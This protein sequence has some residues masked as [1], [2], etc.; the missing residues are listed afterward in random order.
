MSVKRGLPDEASTNG[1][2]TPLKRDYH[3]LDTNK[4]DMEACAQELD[5]ED[6]TEFFE[7]L[8]ETSWHLLD[9]SEDATA[10]VPTLSQPEC[11]TGF[12][13]A[14]GKQLARPSDAAMQ[15][16][17]KRLKLDDTDDGALLVHTPE[18]ASILAQA[19][20]ATTPQRGVFQ[21]P[22]EHSKPSISSTPFTRMRPASVLGTSRSR[23]LS[24]ISPNT[25]EHFQKPIYLGITP[26]SYR[27]GLAAGASSRTKFTPPFKK[28]AKLE[29][30]APAPRVPLFNL[31]PCMLRHSYQQLGLVPKRTAWR[32]AVSQ[33]VPLEA[34]MI[35]Q[36]PQQAAHYLF[37]TAGATHGPTELLKTLHRLGAHRATE[38]WV[39]NHYAV[40]LW[41]LAG[42][43][44]VCPVQ[45]HMYWSY[46]AVLRQMRYRYER[47]VHCGQSSVVKQIQEQRC[48]PGKPMVL[49]VYHIHP[50]A[51]SEEPATTILQLTDGWYRIRAALDA[52]LT[53]A[54]ERG[55]IR[56]GQKLG[57]TAAKLEAFGEGTPVLDAFHTSD[58]SISANSCQHMRWDTRLGAHPRSF[59]STL[60]RLIADGGIVGLMDICLDRVY[61]TG[62]IQGELDARGQTVFTGS[63][64]GT[65]EEQER[66]RAWA[67]QRQEAQGT[68]ALM[69][70]RVQASL[71][72][73]EPR[74]RPCE[75]LDAVSI[76]DV[77]SLLADVE[78]TANPCARLE[79]VQRE[80][81]G[82]AR[83]AALLWSARARASALD[84][85]HTD[86]HTSILD[87]LC[88]P[89]RVKAFCI[90][91][92]HD[93]QRT[94]RTT[95]RSV[96]LTVWDPPPFLKEGARLQVSHLIPTQRDAWRARDAAA[97]VFLATTR[98]TTWHHI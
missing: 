49:C 96:Q 37:R 82:Q 44:A 21:S 68:L 27:A 19:Q 14:S 91:R 76:Q 23:P 24:P 25:V 65:D 4:A 35:L 72:W 89:R 95:R 73:L 2:D 61:P 56:V 93:A 74:V 22:C 55:K 63:Q 13:N 75:P 66:Q 38:K 32:E 52:P 90:V 10:A 58:L 94:K 50:I 7:S 54:V 92:F 88:A 3:I 36:D 1:A 30:D 85:P 62:Y 70:Q 64:Y 79:E 16:A 5:F 71:Q 11:G 31:E 34:C 83:L 59:V 51:H 86:A 60:G 97:D 12:L 77:R 29:H 28:G 8:D 84:A 81:S 9:A 48:S 26:R 57:I 98:Q 40:I 69:A 46:D 67:V 80:H 39:V 6:D 87:A 17:A 18:R 53:R 42:M 47:E 78:A 45:A 33:G 41:K 15:A 43:A 20:A